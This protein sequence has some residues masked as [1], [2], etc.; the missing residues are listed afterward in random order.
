MLG[1]IGGQAISGTTYTHTDLWK[2]LWPDAANGAVGSPLY[3]G[4]TPYKDAGGYEIPAGSRVELTP[5]Q[6]LLTAP[7]AFRAQTAEY[8]NR[9][10]LDFTVGGRI[11]GGHITTPN[12]LLY[13]IGTTV[14]VGGTDGNIAANAVNINAKG[15]D[16]D[17]GSDNL[18][19]TSSSRLDIEAGG[20][21][22]ING[23]SE[24]TV[25]SQSRLDLK[26]ANGMS[27]LRGK[28]GVQI[29]SSDDSIYLRPNI[30][31]QGSGALK[32]S[33]P[34]STTAKNPMEVKTYLLA[35]AASTSS[36]K[37]ETDIGVGTYSLMIIG[38]Q[39]I[40]STIQDFYIER[41]PT[42]QNWTIKLTR[43][44]LDTAVDNVTVHVLVV[45][46]NWVDDRRAP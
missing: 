29:E 36:A 13:T 21:L 9:A 3:L 16:I 12:N 25:N 23:S 15:V 22:Y 17:A 33:V 43:S 46:R 30:E 2:A 20:I 35:F 11:S 40:A 28:T 44:N 32:W 5:R 24:S 26:S 1:G 4:I 45:T 42:T 7:Y 27:Y 19:L 37:L 14:N 8:A 31:V 6:T 18:K 39:G 34:G 41:N 38:L 10:S